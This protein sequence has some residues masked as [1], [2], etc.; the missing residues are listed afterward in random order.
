MSMTNWK[1][2]PTVSNPNY[3]GSGSIS[4]NDVKTAVNAVRQG[5]SYGKKAISSVATMVSKNNKNLAKVNR[6]INCETRF[7]SE[8]VTGTALSATSGT[9]YLLNDMKKGDTIGTREGNCIGMRNICIQ[10]QIESVLSIPDAGNSVRVMLVYDKQTNGAI[11]TLADL[12]YLGGTAV[13]NVI[14]CRNP[15]TKSRFQVLYDR[16]INIYAYPST[17]ATPASGVANA[18]RVNFKINKSWKKVKKTMYSDADAGDVTDIIHG[19]LYLVYIPMIANFTNHRH[20][21]L[22]TYEP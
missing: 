18:K 21:S 14:S 8:S 7:I 9:F 6:I 1:S 12:L 20:H 16:L 10:G 3:R 13:Q 5:Y 11:F 15:N 4:F 19:S 2:Y 22:L 17:T